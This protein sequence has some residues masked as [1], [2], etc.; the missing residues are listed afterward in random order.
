MPS[1]CRHATVA[2][3]AL[4]WF[5]AANLFAQE[6]GDANP[7]LDIATDMNSAATQL[8]KLH[9]G[10]P[11]QDPQQ[12]AL[13]ET[14]RPDQGVGETTSGRKGGSVNPNPSKPAADSVIRSGPGG[15]GKLHAERRDGK[16][17][18]ELPAKEARADSSIARGRLSQSLSK[19]PRALFCSTGRRKSITR[20]GAGSRCRK[21]S[22]RRS[23]AGGY[24]SASSRE[25]SRRRRINHDIGH[26]DR[27]GGFAV[28]TSVLRGAA[29]GCPASRRGWGTAGRG[30]FRHG[31]V[32]A[33]CRIHDRQRTVRRLDSFARI[34]SVSIDS[35]PPRMVPL[36]EVDRI[37]L[38]SA[39][40]PTVQWIGQENHDVVQAGPNAG[41]NGIQDVH[42]ASWH[43]DRGRSLSPKCHHGQHRR[44]GPG[45]APG[46]EQ[47][48]VRRDWSASPAGGSDSADLYL[49]P[50]AGRLF[51]SAVRRH[52]DVR[53]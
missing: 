36:D 35:D 21:A 22:W 28:R 7:L 48:A 29:T 4:C 50:P 49:E 31:V 8:G 51:R 15:M 30:E 26:Y 53:R 3:I 38:G 52:V 41:A 5:S 47:H 42:S 39:T 27:R 34:R 6:D 46:A 17:W 37:E 18:A 1:N 13:E 20:F 23:T 32:S 10:K 45:L 24:N 16:Q 43:L 11:A 19:N 12:N 9:T 33:R 14:R 44:H 40:V 25:Y 2:A